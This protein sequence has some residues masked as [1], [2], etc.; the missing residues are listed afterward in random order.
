MGHVCMHQSERRRFGEYSTLARSRTH[1][2]TSH[3]YAYATRTRLH[4]QPNMCRTC[5]Y[6]AESD[7][8]DGAGEHVCEVRGV[9]AGGW[10]VRV[11]VGT[12]PVRHLGDF[13]Y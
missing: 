5:T 12:L 8:A 7:A 3:L 1:T 13:C 4:T 11:E 2:Y 10:V 6:P 9:G